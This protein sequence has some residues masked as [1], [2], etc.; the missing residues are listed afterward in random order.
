MTKQIQGDK[1]WAEIAECWKKIPCPMHPWPSEM[2]IYKRF[3]QEAL[4]GVKYPKILILGAT[5]EMRDLAH[6]FKNAEITCVDINLDI[7]LAMS[8][9]IKHKER[10]KEEIWVKGDWIT[11]P[12]RKNYYH[13]ILGEAVL[14]NVEI[15]LWSKFLKHLNE[16]LK[17]KGAFITRVV[18]TVNLN[19]E[20]FGKGLDDIFE[21]TNANKLNAQELRILLFVRI[22]HPKIKTMSDYDIFRTVSEFWHSE[23]QRFFHPDPYIQKLLN[24]I[25]ENYNWPP[26]SN[27]HRWSSRTKEICEKYLKRYFKIVKIKYG[28]GETPCPISYHPIYLLAPR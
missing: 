3:S 23:K 27:C 12:L 21:Y 16:L 25:K 28:K 13:L 20:W 18:T 6:S 17:A 11:M 19:S 1:F 10:I 15:F 5:P 8:E 14:G 24:Q 9:L 2:R 26:K 4:K 22:W 7:I